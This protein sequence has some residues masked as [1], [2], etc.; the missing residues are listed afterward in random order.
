MTVYSRNW[1]AVL[2]E[3]AE[4]TRAAGGLLRDSGAGLVAH[5]GSTTGVFEAPVADDMRRVVSIRRGR[6]E[7]HAEAGDGVAAR[8]GAA[9]GEVAAKIARIDAGR[10]AKVAAGTPPNMWDELDDRW[11]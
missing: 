2:A 8:L 11:L 3:A 10:A 7:M 6:Y 1:P 4:A 5:F 9:A